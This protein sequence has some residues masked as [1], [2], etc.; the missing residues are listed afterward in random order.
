MSG[1][2]KSVV[3]IHGW[4]ASL[5]TFQPVHNYLEKYFCTYSIDLP[6]FGDSQEPK[7][8]WSSEEYADL[9]G[10]FLDKLKIEEPILVGHSFGGKVSIRLAAAR[11][12]NKVI[13]VGSAGIKPKRK[14][15]YY[16]KV[17]S[18]KLAKNIF[19]LPVLNKYSEK[20]L[21]NFKKKTGSDDYRNASGIMQQI[22]VKVVNEDIRWLPQ[23]K[24]P[25]LLVWGENDTATPVGDGKIMEQ[26]ML[27]AG[28]VILKKAGHYAYLDKFNE[29]VIIISSFLKKDMVSKGE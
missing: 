15:E 10:K 4:G 25:T 23:I 28:L 17:Y 22:F 12:I 27:D 11:K 3:L 7:E 18:Y 6:G 19:K 9:V 5:K 24:V 13:L 2:G 16:V 1:E 14:P 21:S 29:F 20:V 8:V 26:G